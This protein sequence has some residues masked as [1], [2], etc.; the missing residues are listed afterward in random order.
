M[1]KTICITIALYLITIG[2]FAQDID[3]ALEYYKTGQ[4]SKAAP[5]FEVALI[6]LAKKSDKNDTLHYANYMRYAALSFEKLQQFDKAEN[7]YLQLKEM[8]KN[9]SIASN[10][11]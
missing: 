11:F 2:L 7:Y 9:E 6:I 10:H 5:E 1:K 4:Y 3:K 8:F